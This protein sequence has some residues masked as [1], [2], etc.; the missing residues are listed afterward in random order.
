MKIE[1]LVTIHHGSTRTRS[2]KAKQDWVDAIRQPRVVN[3]VKYVGC[4]ANECN[5]LILPA[6]LPLE[7]TRWLSV[8]DH[9]WRS[10]KEPILEHQSIAALGPS[11]SRARDGYQVI[12]Q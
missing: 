12:R 7:A 2:V 11:R 1:T 6:G 8:A 5:H 10:R 4:Q 9:H 3:P